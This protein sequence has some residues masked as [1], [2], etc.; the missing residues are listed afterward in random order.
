MRG[1]AGKLETGEP[2]RLVGRQLQ[3]LDL[4]GDGDAHADQAGLHGDLAQ[5]IER[6]QALGNEQTLRMAV[7]AA[8]PVG[9]GG[10]RQHAH[11]DAEFALQPGLQRAGKI[12]AGI[13][14]R[15]ERLGLLLDRGE[16]VRPPLEDLA[17]LVDRQAGAGQRGRPPLAG[18]QVGQVGQ[19]VGLLAI[20]AEQ[21]HH[22][23]RGVG[24][25]L[26]DLDQ[27]LVARQFAGQQRVGE[28]LLQRRDRVAAARPA[29][30]RYRPCRPRPAEHAA[31][32]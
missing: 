28:H 17:H 5:L 18:Q 4:G 3:R 22:C 27:F 14:Q 11:D 20:G 15:G 26:G 6:R 23:G 9:H 10:D 31:A 32:R 1:V 7:V 29:I 21:L 2:P 12:V 30:R 13:E 24:R 8:A 25:G 16:M 19:T